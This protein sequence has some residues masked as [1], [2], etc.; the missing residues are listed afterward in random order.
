M[1]R[2]FML[3]G[4]IGGLISVILAAFSAHGLK[5]F[6][7]EPLIIT[8]KTAIEYQFTHSLVLILLAL[9]MIVKPDVRQFSIAGWGLIVGILC[10]SGS[11]YLYALTAMKVF[12][13]ATPLGGVA[14]LIGWGHFA[15]GV[16]KAF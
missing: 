12:T 11:L 15:R 9:T 7:T 4:T 16:W 5:N 10:F 2:I 1:P 3:S 14:F 13:V 6:V 8:F